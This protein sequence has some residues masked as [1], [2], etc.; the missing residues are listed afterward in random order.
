MPYLFK[1]LVMIG[2]S[3]MAAVVAAVACD[4]SQSML[5]HHHYR[6]LLAIITISSLPRLVAVSDHY[7]IILTFNHCSIFITDGNLQ[8][9]SLPIAPHHH[10]YITI[11]HGRSRSLLYH[12]FLW[13]LNVIS[14]NNTLSPLPMAAQDRYCIILS[15]GFLP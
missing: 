9:S 12:H 2:G 4:G 14:L 5:N 6:R 1:H 8:S 10:Y 15:D 13:L 7:Y 3:V 11:T